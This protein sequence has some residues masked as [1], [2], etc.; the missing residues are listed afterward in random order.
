MNKTLYRL[1]IACTFPVAWLV[2]PVCFLLFNRKEVIDDIT[3]F[4]QL[5]AQAFVKGERL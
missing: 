1:M 4:Y 3:E 5:A 2:I